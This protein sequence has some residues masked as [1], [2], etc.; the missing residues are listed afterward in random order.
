MARL[1]LVLFLSLPLLAPR[2]FCV[3][4]H[5]GGHDGEPV[6]PTHPAGGEH[7]EHDGGPG[8]DCPCCHYQPDLGLH[9][10]ADGV[11]MSPAAQ[12]GAP[13]LPRVLPSSKADPHADPP[14][15]GV[16]RFVSLCTFR[17]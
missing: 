16:P 11:P 13:S 12:D 3:C 10:P 7:D 8:D 9:K 15:P 2:L 5:E 17:N 4:G 1:L 14:P 6:H